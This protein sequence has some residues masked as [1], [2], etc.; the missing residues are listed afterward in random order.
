[1]A[2]LTNSH[3]QA[4]AGGAAAATGLDLTGRHVSGDGGWTGTLLGPALTT[5]SGG[6]GRQVRMRVEPDGPS[7]LVP[8]DLLDE[9]PDGTL[10]LPL[11]RSALD[12]V[13]QS[14]IAGLSAAETLI[15]GRAAARTASATAEEGT[16]AQNE[17][18]VIPLIAEELRVTTEQVATGGVRVHQTV[19]ERQE[20][21]RV[22][23]L[24]DHVD[25]ERVA[26]NRLV[27]G[28]TAPAVRQEGDV[29]VVP[30]LEEVVVVEKRLM[31][32][33]ELRIHLRRVQEEHTETVTLRREE[34]HVE[35]F[36]PG[37]QQ[38][39]QQTGAGTTAPLSGQNAG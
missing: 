17:R 24:R 36:A 39:M 6:G 19:T 37:E 31:V 38:Q 15:P 9:R 30:L 16:Q 18:I 35:R 3:G 1:M 13:A 20:D 8:L 14:E 11:T 34:A 21:V 5:T 26:V 27:E 2:T 7:A 29:M 23:L 10:Y 33:E 25:V 32:R 4:P 22:A 28:T 12:L